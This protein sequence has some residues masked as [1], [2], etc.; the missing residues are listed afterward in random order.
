MKRIRD[1]FKSKVNTVNSNTVYT[2]LKKEQY[3]MIFMVGFEAGR[4]NCPICSTELEDVNVE[5]NKVYNKYS[6][7]L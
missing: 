1:L 5:F 6:S 4:R 7:I 3:K 2:N